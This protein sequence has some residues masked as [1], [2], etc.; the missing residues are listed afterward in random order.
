M[1]LKSQFMHCHSRQVFDELS[2][3]KQGEMG[4]SSLSTKIPQKP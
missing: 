4:K 1:S 3:A 2:K